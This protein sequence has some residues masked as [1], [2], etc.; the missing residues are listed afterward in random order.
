MFQHLVARYQSN[1]FQ[2]SFIT[3]RNTVKIK[4][5]KA[6]VLIEFMLQTKNK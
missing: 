4:K 2:T 5:E 1:L 6:L 3:V